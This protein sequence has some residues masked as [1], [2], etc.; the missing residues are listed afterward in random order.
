MEV[1][2]S[3]T[4]EIKQTIDLRHTSSIVAAI[5]IHETTCVTSDHVGFTKFPIYPTI[6]FTYRAI[7][8]M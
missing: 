4:H 6:I 1:L 7:G 2:Q 3:T 5:V 8:K